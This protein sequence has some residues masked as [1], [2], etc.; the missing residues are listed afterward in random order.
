MK[1]IM[2]IC[3]VVIVCSIAAGAVGGVVLLWRE[4]FRS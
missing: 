3:L 1:D 2:D 4:V